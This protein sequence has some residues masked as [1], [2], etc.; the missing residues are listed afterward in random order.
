MKKFTF[1]LLGLF[2]AA[3][4]LAAI[5]HS[6]KNHGDWIDLLIAAAFAYGAFTAFRK[7]G[8]LTP[9]S[10]SAGKDRPWQR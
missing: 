9:R 7:V 5:T 2:A 8:R 1:V 10:E 4:T 6:A 3:M